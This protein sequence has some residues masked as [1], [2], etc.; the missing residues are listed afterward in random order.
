MLQNQI[1]LFNNFAKKPWKKKIKMNMN[2]I[3]KIMNNM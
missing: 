3:N 1:K 2:F